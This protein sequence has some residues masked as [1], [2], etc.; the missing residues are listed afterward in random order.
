[1]TIAIWKIIP[2]FLLF[3]GTGLEDCYQCDKIG[4][5]YASMTS[6]VEEQCL[7]ASFTE[8]NLSKSLV[9]DTLTA[10]IVY[11]STSYFLYKG[12]TMGFEYELLERF[13]KEM[14]MELEIVVSNNIDD[15]IS[16][17]LA[18]KADLIAHGLA[19]TE[20]RQKEVQFTDYLYLSRQVLVQKKPEN[21]RRLT[22]DNLNKK[23]AKD[24]IELIGDTIT[25]RNGSAYKARLE[26]LNQEIGGGI[27]LNVLDG[28]Y[29]TDRIIEMV[30]QDSIDYTV[31]DDYLAHINASYMP[32]LDVETPL[33]TKQRIAWAV[34]PGDTDLLKKLNTWVKKARKT[35]DYFVI[36]NKYFKNTKYFERRIKSPFYS[37]KDS[38][39]SKY[40]PI[41]KKEAQSIGW[42]WKL[43]A[44]IIYQESQ[45][46][47]NVQSWVGAVGL[48]QLMPT[49]AKSLGVSDSKNPEENI[50]G[51]IK[52]LGQ[53]YERLGHI[54]DSVERIKFTLASY[55]CGFS[56]VQDAQ[57]L[58]ES[59]GKNKI[60]WDGNVAEM[61][62][63]LSD[64]LYYHRPNIKHGYV[65]GRQPYNYVKDIFQR[66][67][68]YAYFIKS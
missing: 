22:A 48:M 25:V 68:H 37:L 33:S 42:D 43:I 61:L 35:T 57:T 47:P 63:K 11:S 2:L 14:D 50:K 30:D 51:G 24:P 27:H 32:D 3:T 67:D 52:Y 20:E 1:M 64:P 56:H 65:R 9:K 49:T 36:Y 23:L 21:W 13:A 45:F 62:L 40:D 12:Q 5:A 17:L 38:Q 44:S 55:N 59:E 7:S 46:D 41:I 58:A 54:P 28:S 39:I 15:L 60:V 18:G 4:G 29:S 66:Y 53:L 31:A 16:D 34:K 26:N 8:A 19:I 6:K 10:L